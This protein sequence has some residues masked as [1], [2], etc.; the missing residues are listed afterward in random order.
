VCQG[1]T[2][3]LPMLMCYW[4]KGGSVASPP[5]WS[6]D[7]PPQTHA[8]VLQGERVALDVSKLESYRLFPGQVV[9]VQGVNPTAKKVIAGKII[10]QLVP[11]HSASVKS[12]EQKQAG[13][14]LAPSTWERRHIRP[15][16]CLSLD[17]YDLL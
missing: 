1:S 5:P 14:F 17:I 10:S 3:T 9:A 16:P 2:S 6:E 8:G 12:P 15:L 7:L 13:V 4:E 11:K